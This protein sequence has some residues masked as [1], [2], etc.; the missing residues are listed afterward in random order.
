MRLL[1]IAILISAV[2][3]GA[4]LRERH[5]TAANDISAGSGVANLHSSIELETGPTIGVGSASFDQQ[6][7]RLTVPIAT[8]GSIVNGY[9]AFHVHLRWDPKLFRFGDA[10]ATGGLFAPSPSGF[11]LC[12]PGQ[13]DGDGGGVVFGCAGVVVCFIPSGGCQVFPVYTKPGL[14]ATIVLVARHPGCSILHLV[15]FGAPDNDP[16][17]TYTRSGSVPDRRDRTTVSR[18]RNRTQAGP[19][20]RRGPLLRRSSGRAI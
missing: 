12:S 16:G 10:N 1:A 8:T 3:A 2:V 19:S 18:R 11:F 13:V 4:A 14:L 5:A 7:G 20:A 9:S 15:T 17:G 6:S